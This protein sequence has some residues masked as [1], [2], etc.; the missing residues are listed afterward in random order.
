MAETQETKS[1]EIHPDFPVEPIDGSI[2]GAQP[3]V[4]LS[5]SA[6]GRYCRPT[7]SPSEI[8]RRFEAAD[9]LVG[10]LVSYFKRK[11]KENPEWTDEKNYERIRLALIQKADEGKWPYTSAEQAWIMSQL[12]VR[13][14]T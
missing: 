7:R 13:S 8:K 9:D 2:G 10:Q 4:L 5:K 3:K 12:R 14:V 11:K 6:D 1:Q